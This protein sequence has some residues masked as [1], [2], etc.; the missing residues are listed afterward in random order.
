MLGGGLAGSYLK[1]KLAHF[2]N[3]AD[4]SGGGISIF[5]EGF[6]PLWQFKK[7]DIGSIGR[8]RIALMSGEWNDNGMPFIN[9][10]DHDTM[11]IVE[12][13]WGLELR[14]RFGLNEEKYWYID[15][16]PEFQRWDSASLPDAVDP[17]FQGTNISFGLAW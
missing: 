2:S 3:K 8:G 17:S 12:V 10:T 5:G 4:Y 14:R 16:M 1:Y 6:Y 9:E 11:T 15:L 13:A 7:T